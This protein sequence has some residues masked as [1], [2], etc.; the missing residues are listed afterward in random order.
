MGLTAVYRYVVLILITGVILFLSL[1]PLPVA[2]F[3][4]QHSMRG[5]II[6]M[7][8]AFSTGDCRLLMV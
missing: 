3:L 5:I 2:H 8:P 7:P 1:N 4:G 6:N